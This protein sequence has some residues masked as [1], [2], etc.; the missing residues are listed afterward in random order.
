MLSDPLTRSDE[1]SRNL[2]ES[3]VSLGKCC[4]NS[5]STET[6]EHTCPAN[7]TGPVEQDLCVPL[8]QIGQMLHSFFTS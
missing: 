8:V 7:S 2:D 1:Q 3:G 5:A 6:V 4:S